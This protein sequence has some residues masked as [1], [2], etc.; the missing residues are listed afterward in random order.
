MITMPP[1]RIL[2][3]KGPKLAAQGYKNQAA[4]GLQE[5]CIQANQKWLT[6]SAKVL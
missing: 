6:P 1:W 4:G 3:G 5:Y 2:M